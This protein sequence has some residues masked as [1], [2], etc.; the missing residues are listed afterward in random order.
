[1]SECPSWCTASPS[2]EL[3]SVTVGR[4]G[5]FR[6]AVIK[7]DEWLQ[8]RVYV[9]YQPDPPGTADVVLGWREADGLGELLTRLGH[10]RLGRLIR[11]AAET[12]CL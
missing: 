4:S 2:H 1:M 6:V 3:H 7:D 11:Q 8:P 9:G 12:A 10:R 5:R